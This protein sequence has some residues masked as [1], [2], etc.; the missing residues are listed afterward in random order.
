MQDFSNHGGRLGAAM[1][2]F[3]HAPTPWIDLSTGI[4]PV[5]YPAPLAS[6]EAR[7]RLPEPE[8]LAAL[9][10][11]AAR[12]FGLPPE[13]VLATA[14]GEAAIR[15]LAAVIP[16]SR[17]GVAEPAYGGHRQS[18]TEAGAT[19]VGVSRQDLAGA[20]LDLEVLAVVNPNNP[21]GA[22]TPPEALAALAEVMGAWGGWLIVDE[23]FVEVAPELSVAT[24]AGHASHRIWPAPRLIALRSF[25]KFYGLAG[26]RLGFVTG[27]PVLIARLRRRQGDWPVSADALAA[28]WAAYADAAWAEATRTRLAE[29]ARRLDDLLQRAGFKIVGGCDLFRL[30]AADDAAAR[31]VRLAEA[32]ILTRPFDAAP[33]WL[34]FGLP[35][36]D[37][38]PRLQALL[39]E[40]S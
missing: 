33:R 13:M 28:G 19:V 4:N 22:V 30:A 25:G 1:R 7:A 16:A 37:Q 29:D 5:A 32:G 31:F 3:P 21:D 36:P 11:A 2:R 23:A 17:V 35:A 10:A 9:E 24:L 20:V 40:L 6:A 15:L 8:A 39:E 12:A 27:H 14:G 34:R 26:L 38:W 18:W